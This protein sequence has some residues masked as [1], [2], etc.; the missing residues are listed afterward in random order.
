MRVC[1]GAVLLCASAEAGFSHA[2]RHKSSS[3]SS[4]GDMLVS[5]AELLHI[6]TPPFVY[7]SDSVGS[8]QEL[9]DALWAGNWVDSVAGR[10]SVANPALQ[11]LLEKQMVDDA[12]TSSR[13]GALQGQSRWE[14]VL[15][16]LFR[17]RSQRMIPIETAALSIM[18][19]YYRV[20]KP[21]WQA[22]SYFGKSVMS[23][24]WVESLCDDAIERDPGP[25]YP[26][27]EGLTAAVFDNLMMN[28]DY[29]SFAT[30][31]SGGRKIEMT[32]WATVFLPAATMPSTFT[33]MANLLGEVAYFGEILTWKILLTA[34]ASW[35]QIS[36]ATRNS[37]GSTTW[38]WR[39]MAICGR[40][41]I[42]YRRT[43]QPNSTFTIR[44]LT[45]AEFV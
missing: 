27:A 23:R 44:S 11:L 38:I 28:V 33:G 42:S 13:F 35:R 22:V 10:F 17:A 20:P 2:K 16:A 36:L 41:R 8:R 31:D 19:L 24:S 7:N 29:S 43:R 26:V 1:M 32:N 18:W 12:D 6:R 30:S 4:A 3:G 34:S 45:A 9:I 21:V 5:L 14:A 37:D 40:P 39:Q 15:S 25:S